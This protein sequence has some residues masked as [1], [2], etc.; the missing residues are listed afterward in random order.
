MQNCVGFPTLYW[1]GREHD[2]DVL[3]TDL[4]G[5]SLEHLFVYC[6]EKFSLKTVIMIADQLLDRLESM[7][8]R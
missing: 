2:Y 3:I 5:P 4:L 7:H 6:E 1:F 8:D